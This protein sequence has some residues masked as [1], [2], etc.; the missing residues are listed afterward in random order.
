MRIVLEELADQA[1]KLKEQQAY[2]DRLAI[3]A[4]R[5]GCS[6]PAIGRALGVTKQS[7]QRKYSAMMPEPLQS[8]GHGA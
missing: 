4:R 3:E 7:V 1:V 6:W 8:P 5:E 2:I